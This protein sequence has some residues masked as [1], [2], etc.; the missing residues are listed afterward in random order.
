M[1]IPIVAGIYAEH[2]IRVDYPRNLRPV[3]IGSGI[4]D[5]LLQPTPGVEPWGGELP[6]M[7]RGGINWREACYRVAG[8]RLV[9]IEGDG[10]ITDLGEVRDGGTV[11]FDYGFDRL[12][13]CAGGTLY[14]WDGVALTA[15]ADKDLGAVQSFVWSDGYYVCTDGINITVTELADPTAADPLKYGGAE[16]DPD[17]VYALHKIRREVYAVNRNTIE[18][19]QN[20]GGSLFPFSR[21]DGAQVQKGSV[22]IH[23]SCV[24]ADTIAF[25]GG[26]RNEAVSIYSAVNGQ[27][28]R[29]GT[30]ETDRILAALSPTQLADIEVETMADEIGALLLVHLP[31][32]TLA[33]DG[34]ASQM[35]GQPI[36]LD[37]RS[38]MLFEPYRARHPVLCYGHW[39]VSDTESPQLGRLTNQVATHWGDHTAWSFATPILWGGGPS[40]L[41]HRLELTALTGDVPLTEIPV[42]WTAYS[43]DGET[44]SQDRGTSL[45]ATGYRAHRIAWMQQGYIRQWRIQRF[46]GYAPLSVLS[47]DAQMEPLGV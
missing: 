26:G 36:W 16:A 30:L 20:V 22:G 38:G 19:F 46:R 13:V 3:G 2:G 14:Y 27:A 25:V 44:W 28:Q 35:L 12:A 43:H 5:Y 31:D 1:N 42:A 45:G 10:A 9:L 8:T 18:V 15:V 17:P 47:L 29:I 24:W 7:D 39:I 41:I 4:S 6:G 33:Y 34:T 21:I 23:A 11:T 32:R 40:A 37:L